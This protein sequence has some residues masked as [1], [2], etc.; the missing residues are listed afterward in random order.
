MRQ[1]TRT[2][3]MAR[4]GAICAALAIVLSTGACRTSLRP[5]AAIAPLTSADEAG[6]REQLRSRLASF[7]GARS[8]MQIR[9]THDGRTESFRAQLA[10]H[11]A[12]RMEFTAYTPVGTTALKMTATGAQVTFDPQ[13][14]EGSLGFFRS[15]LT[16]AE[17][18]L[19]LLGIPP[20]EDAQYVFAPAGLS[21]ATIDDA[22]FTFE[23][24]AF[25]AKRVTIE[26][27]GSRVVIEHLEVVAAQ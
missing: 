22:R 17:L 15:S 25:P 23:P 12:Q 2:S 27:A 4:A 3:S 9:A 8:L 14:P 13:P 11:D 26:R 5:G 18:G 7:R 16:P 10:V 21:E 20:R 19:L 6:A 1:T 24:P